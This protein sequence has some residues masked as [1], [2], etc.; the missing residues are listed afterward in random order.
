MNEHNNSGNEQA[1][2]HD[3]QG[4]RRRSGRRWV[5]N[6]LL[7]VTAGALTLAGV[8][9]AHGGAGLHGHG[10]HDLMDPASMDKHVDAIVNHVLADG[11]TEQKAKVSAIAKAALTD[12]R[13]IQEQ[14]HAAHAQAAALLTQP[15]IDRVALEQLRATEISQLD[16]ASKRITQA[17][18]D[19]D[20][21]LTPEQ[22][23]KLGEQLKKHHGMM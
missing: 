21:V 19:A 2:E 11:T 22:R 8:T 1:T 23:V 20:D 6:I 14:M 7:A 18:L 9:F 5:I 3:Q 13:P 12:L 15:T 10:M 4:G 17:I 16:A